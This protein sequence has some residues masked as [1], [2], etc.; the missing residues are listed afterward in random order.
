MGRLCD[1]LTRT[2][3]AQ[4][5]AMN[6]A[7]LMT[8]VS[9]FVSDL[10]EAGVSGVTICSYVKAVKSWARFN[11]TKLDE[12]VNVPDS[13]P[14]YAEEVIPTLGE[15]QTFLDHCDPIEHFTY[16]VQRCLQDFTMLKNGSSS[17]KGFASFLVLGMG[18]KLRC[19][20]AMA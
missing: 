15:V 5:A 18:S 13:D 2:T 1:E 16:G 19:H 4:I 20:W 9:G 11:G 6:R 3:P 12:R 8:Y 7:E 10:K 14:R 17:R